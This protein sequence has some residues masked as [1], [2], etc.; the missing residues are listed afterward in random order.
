MI[1]V[2]FNEENLKG[3]TRAMPSA[4]F[5]YL[6]DPKWMESDLSKHI[7]KDIARAEWGGGDFF[8]GPFSG[9]SHNELPNGVKMLLMMINADIPEHLYLESC[10]IGDNCWKYLQFIPEDKKILLHG[11]SFPDPSWIFEYYPIHM[12]CIDD[13][14]IIDGLDVFANYNSMQILRSQGKDVSKINPRKLL[15]HD[16]SKLNYK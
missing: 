3:K 9:H 1:N 8:K 10:Y 7:V 4:L 11:N 15:A 13:D 12:Y 2:T 16:R 14:T 6:W 5:R